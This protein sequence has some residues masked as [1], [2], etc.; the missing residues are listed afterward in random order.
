[1][2]FRICINRIDTISFYNSISCDFNIKLTTCESA[3]NADDGLYRFS[4]QERAFMHALIMMHFERKIFTI[5]K[6]CFYPVFK[7][8]LLLYLKCEC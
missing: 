7:N 6:H 5:Y 8:L 4:K 1:M 2:L 3:T